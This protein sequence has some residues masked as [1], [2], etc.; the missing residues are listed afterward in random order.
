[1]AVWRVLKEGRGSALK[2]R[3][4]ARKVWNMF[5]P[6]TVPYAMIWYAFGSLMEERE[7]ILTAMTPM[8]VIQD[9]CKK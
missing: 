6:K 7:G 9:D 3:G 2:A 5:D 1:M 4:P 8:N